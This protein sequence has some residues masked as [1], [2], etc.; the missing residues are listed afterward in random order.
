M[1]DQDLPSPEKMI[2]K[3]VYSCEFSALFLSHCIS[4]APLKIKTQNFL[5][6]LKK[7]NAQPFPF[8]LCSEAAFIGAIRVCCWGSDQ[9]RGMVCGLVSL[10]N[11]V[12][13]KICLALKSKVA[14]VP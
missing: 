2:R 14:T 9:E 6:S 1:K 10:Q 12:C 3:K 7:S 4:I 8:C 5:Y 11:N 13:P